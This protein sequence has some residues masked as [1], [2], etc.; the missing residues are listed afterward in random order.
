[1]VVAA[2]VEAVAVDE[3]ESVEEEDE[4]PL[5]RRGVYRGDMI[6]VVR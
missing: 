6:D 4:G 1:V 2:A 3:A 5:H